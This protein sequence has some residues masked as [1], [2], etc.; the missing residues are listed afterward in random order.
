MPEI[1]RDAAERE[2]DVDQ[3]ADVEFR[4]Y[5]VETHLKPL[6]SAGVR[7]VGDVRYF[8]VTGIDEAKD[9]LRSLT[10][11]TDICFA[12]GTQGYILEVFQGGH[13]NPYL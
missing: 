5:C 10:D 11:V 2:R 9:V 1:S 8:R 4:S 7:R 6:Y 13:T 3:D 12:S